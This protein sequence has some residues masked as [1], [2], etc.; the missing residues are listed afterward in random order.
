MF[1]KL[2]LKSSVIQVTETRIITLI[3]LIFIAIFLI[4]S[5]VYYIFALQSPYIFTSG[6]IIASPP[7]LTVN[8]SQIYW[9]QIM[10]GNSV[11]RTITLRNTGGQ[12]TS[13]LQFATT[14]WLNSTDIGLR[15]SWD[16]KGASLA[17]GAYVDVTFTLTVAVSA[18]PSDFSFNI[19]IIT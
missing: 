17:A 3:S 8:P 10:P 18:S 11:S 12:P 1:Q 2:K 15:L 16:Y 14:D 5:T 6:S 19:V 9:G 7:N 13:L 4:S